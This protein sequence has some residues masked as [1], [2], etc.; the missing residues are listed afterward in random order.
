MD[1]LSKGLPEFLL[2]LYSRHGK[3]LSDNLKFYKI[4][5]LEVSSSLKLSYWL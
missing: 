4:K 5:L 3:N 1:A 2:E